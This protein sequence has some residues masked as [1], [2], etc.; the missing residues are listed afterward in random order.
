[1][2]PIIERLYGIAG[3]VASP[4]PGPLITAALALRLHLMY[5]NN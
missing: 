2:A 4:A 5:V 3:R 1:M